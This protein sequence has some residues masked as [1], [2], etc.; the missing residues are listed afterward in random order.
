MVASNVPAAGSGVDYSNNAQ[1]LAGLNTHITI[2]RDA[3]RL[4]YFIQNQSASQLYAVFDRESGDTVTV[5]I[6]E[7]AALA[8][9]PGGYV[10]MQSMPHS[11]R[12]RVMSAVANPQVAARAW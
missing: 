12:I 4:G 3:F 1:S 2:P 11:G 5:Y 9:S 10:D 7:A 6:L 8:G